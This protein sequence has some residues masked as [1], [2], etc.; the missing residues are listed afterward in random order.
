MQYRNR[1]LPA[2]LAALLALVLACA[3]ATPA[4][5]DDAYD[6]PDAD[7]AILSDV[8]TD[9]FVT[10]SI[11]ESDYQGGTIPRMDITFRDAVDPESGEWM[12][13]DEILDLVN[14]SYNHSYKATEASVTITVPADYDN[15]EADMWDGVS[16]YTGETDLELDFIRGRGNSTWRQAKKPYKLKFDKK[17]DLFGMGKNKHWALLANYYDQSLS[18]DRLVGWLGDSLGTLGFTPRGVPVDL[19]MNGTYYGS[20]LLMEEVRVD[21]NRLEIDAVPEDANDLSSLAITGDYLLGVSRKP[22]A[23]PYDYFTTSNGSAF[24]YDTPEY[25]EYPTEAGIAQQT[26]LKSHIDRV[27]SAV[28]TQTLVNENGESAWDF[29]DMETLADYWWIQEFTTNVDGFATPSTYTY[30]LADTLE[31]DGSVTVG[32]LYWGPLWDFDFVWGQLFAEGFDNVEATWVA[33]LRQDPEFVAYLKE[34]WAVLDS[35]L[36]E[37]TRQGGILDGYLSELEESWNANREIWPTEDYHDWDYSSCAAALESLRC[38]IEARRAWI[39]AHL[40]E[41]QTTYCK[42]SFVDGGAELESCYVRSGEAAFLDPPEMHDSDERLFDG[43]FTEDGRMYVA[44]E[45]VTEDETYYAVWTD[46]ATATKGEAIYFPQEEIWLAWSTN[47]LYEVLP[48]NA[49][50]KR[51]EWTVEDESVVRLFGDY[52]IANEPAFDE[53]GLAET[54][55]TGRLVAT[56]AEASIK[57]VVFDASARPGDPESI[58]FDEAV[59]V[60]I[61]EDLPL[62]YD[63]EPK[64]NSLYESLDVRF[65]SED[66]S[67]ATVTQLTGVVTGVAAGQTKVNVVTYDYETGEDVVVATIDVSVAA[68]EPVDPDPVD[69]DPVDPKPVDPEPV[70]PAPQPSGNGTKTDTDTKTDAATQT[71]SD[72]KANDN[73]TAEKV[74]A[75]GEPAWALS[76]LLAAACALIAAGALRQS[77]RADRQRF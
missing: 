20:Y 14:S 73:T 71:K 47:I 52:L 50:D 70:N 25:G 38:A 15:T 36:D 11:S 40:D 1:L 8:A 22:T 61:G 23:M 60:S 30:K 44:E 42:V 16:G 76:L 64:P 43:W 54:V 74:P 18:I 31:E 17:V 49:R 10:T 24:T 68:P 65:E 4:H 51:V 21:D 59:T 39:N 29:I 45:P 41:L 28:L 66:E 5:A 34:R 35:K 6:D 46:A 13:G 58:R 75:T 77:E 57:V 33:Y 9:G 56:G 19:F 26:Y 7:N 67:V 48:V 2:L 55:L 53:R 63:A 69:P 37:I 3:C 62:R 27:E 72:T 12:T 32:K